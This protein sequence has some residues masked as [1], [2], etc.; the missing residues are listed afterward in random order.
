MKRFQ[1]S[2]AV[3]ACVLGLSGN[4]MAAGGGSFVP[5]T[6]ADNPYINHSVGQVYNSDGSSARYAVAYLWTSAGIAAGNYNVT[7]GGNNN[8]QSL[9]CWAEWQ[10][11][12]TSTYY[13]GSN[14]TTASGDFTMTITTNVATGGAYAV[15]VICLIPRWTTAPSKLF[16]AN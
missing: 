11:T 9:Q 10:S 3:A 5:Y 12:S 4:L 13:Q 6:P 14:T 7:V 1:M 15:N 16:S 2:I 8:G